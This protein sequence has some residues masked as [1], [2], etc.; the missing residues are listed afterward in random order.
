MEYKKRYIVSFVTNFLKAGLGAVTSF[1]IAREL[2]PNDTGRL[3]FLL[4]TFASLRNLLDLGSSSAFFTFISK[5]NRSQKYIFGFLVWTFFQL[6]LSLFLVSVVLPDYVLKTIW[7]GE[8]KLLIILALLASFMMNQFWQVA[9]Y[10]GEASRKTKQVQIISLATTAIHL[11]AILLLIYSFEFGLYTIFTLI[12]IEWFIAGVFCIKLH[13]CSSFS[14]YSLKANIVSYKNYC[15]PL[16]PY[17]LIS[18]FFEFFEK[19]MLQSFSGSAHQAY[20]GLA[21]RISSVGLLATTSLLKVFWKEG[22]ELKRMNDFENLN[23]LLHQALFFLYSFSFF[24][25]SVFLP[26]TGYLFYFLLGEQYMNG[27]LTFFILLFYPIHQTLGQVLG[28]FVY[29]S[30][31]TRSYSIISSIIT[32]INMGVTYLILA[33]IHSLFQ[34]LVSTQLV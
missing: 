5:E 10:I 23:K 25:V 3:F 15:L 8:S 9:S 7:V 14:T 16:L 26:I 33:P 32:V 17:I 27:H 19:W 29:S 22:A 6:I 4:G 12:S 1:I 30:E 11:V 21:M 34:D 13:T 18:I 24:I 28:T 31:L 20:F 2:G